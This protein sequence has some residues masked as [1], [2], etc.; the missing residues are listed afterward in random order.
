MKKLF[1]IL[2]LCVVGCDNGL[3]YEET[4]VV[5]LKTNLS[6]ES[7]LSA[8]Q[9]LGTVFDHEA[10]LFDDGTRASN[11]LSDI[12]INDG[13]ILGQVQAALQPMVGEGELLR[14]ELL[15]LAADGSLDLT[16]SEISQ[17]G[18]IDDAS[19]AGFAYIM[20]IFS[21]VDQGRTIKI[22]GIPLEVTG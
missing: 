12:Q 15:A 21:V 1:L 7:L 18:E 6:Y 3:N 10:V 20:S 17:L 9:G 4:E 13:Q 5:S 2:S 19:L 22:D 14:D 16:D 8:S 11:E